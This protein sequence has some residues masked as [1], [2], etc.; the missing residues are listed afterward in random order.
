MRALGLHLSPDGAVGGRA[1]VAR[2]AVVGVAH[3]RPLVE[4]LAE[5]DRRRRQPPDG[6]VEDVRCVGDVVTHVR[7][8][9]I[10]SARKCHS[11][12][13]IENSCSVL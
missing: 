3:R 10:H 7:L 9:L 5:L 8:N 1:E 12:K 6:V 13:S 2:Q 11:Q 4:R